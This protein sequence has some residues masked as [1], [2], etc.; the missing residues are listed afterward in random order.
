MK[1]V[2]VETSERRYSSLAVQEYAR[3]CPQHDLKPTLL[4]S[5]LHLP[6]SQ[7]TQTPSEMKILGQQRL[8]KKKFK[9]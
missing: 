9:D 8:F 3:S 6:D 1:N 7:I 5:Q 4:H 2:Y